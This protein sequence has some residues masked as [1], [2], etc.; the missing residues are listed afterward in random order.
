M[1][2]KFVVSTVCD[3]SGPL[4]TIS[5]ATC[6]KVCHSPALS[7]TFFCIFDSVALWIFSFFSRFRSPQL[8][9]ALARVASVRLAAHQIMA[10]LIRRHRRAAT[11][12]S[13]TVAYATRLVAARCRVGALL[14]HA[15]VC[16]CVCVCVRVRVCS[17]VQDNFLLTSSPHN[18]HQNIGT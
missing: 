15:G 9:C 18:L 1:C 5:F 10:A 12:A 2:A 4:Q 17:H 7:L 14:L 13:G 11:H 8:L 3:V 16:V 6:H